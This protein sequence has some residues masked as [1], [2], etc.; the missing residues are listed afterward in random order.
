MATKKKPVA[1]SAKGKAKS[2]FA[3]P[4]DLG[5]DHWV[6]VRVTKSVPAIS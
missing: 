5:P 6:G 2:T 3:G 1:N 4:V